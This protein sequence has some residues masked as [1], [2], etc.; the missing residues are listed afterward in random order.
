MDHL[1]IQTH[2]L[3]RFAA[4]LFDHLEEAQ[5]CDLHLVHDYFWSIPSDELHDVTRPPDNLTIGQVSESLANLARLLSEP[6]TAVSYGLVWL[7][8]VLRTVG[9]SARS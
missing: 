9:H 1:T 8:D 7:A 4:L 5:G 2:D 6:D 3:R